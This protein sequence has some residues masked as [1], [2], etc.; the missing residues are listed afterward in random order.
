MH[1]HQTF[2]QAIHEK[3]ILKIRFDSFEKG[4]IERMCVPFDFAPS[5]RAKDPTSKYQVYD[6]NSPSGKHNL[7]IFPDQIVLIEKTES[8]FDPSTYV[9]WS[10]PYVW[11]V[12]RDWGT[13]S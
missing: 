8:E 7:A 12:K 3:K 4:V 2:L 11:V 6:L 10:K 1:H 5:S 13:Y 9:T